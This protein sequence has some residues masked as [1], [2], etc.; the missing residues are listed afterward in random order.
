MKYVK[1]LG[2]AAVVVAGL[3]A[4]AGAGN[5]SASVLCKTAPN[6]KG[7]CP[8]GWGYSGE[9]HA[10][11]EEK[12][13][14]TT[15][16]KNIECSTSTLKGNLTEGTAVSTETPNGAV[17]AFTEEGCNCEVV[18]VL[19]GELEIHAIGDTGNGTLTSNGLTYTVKC[20]TIFG[21]VH[22]AYVTSHADIGTL[23]G[24]STATIDIT[25]TVERETTS[26][27]CDEEAVWHIKYNVTTPDALWVATA[28]E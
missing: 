6:A 12:P 24:G 5:A 14:T 20:N 8:A 3:M 21:A 15:T 28:T 13:V 11:S 16:F 18:V 23:T 27:L 1:M 10:V 19:K 25:T 17:S 9:F 7:N 4:F 2:L 22:C 26:A